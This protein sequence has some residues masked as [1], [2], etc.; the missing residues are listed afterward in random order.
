MARMVPITVVETP[1]YLTASSK[2]MSEEER[3]LL[4][5][6]LAYNLTV[7]DLIPGTGG[8]RKLRRGLKGKGKRCGARG[9]FSSD[10]GMPLLRTPHTRRTG[11]RI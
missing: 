10:A 5:D 9:S 8:V 2:L 7:G 4:V 3:A 11:G 6:Y 1:A